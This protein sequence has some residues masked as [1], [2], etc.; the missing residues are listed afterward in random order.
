MDLATGK[1]ITR[2]PRRCCARILT[3]RPFTV[4]ENHRHW[5]DMLRAGAYR[6]W[7]SR[8]YDFYLPR[9]AELLKPHDLGHSERILRER[10]SGVALPGIHTSQLTKSPRNRYVWF[11][12]GIWLFRR[13]LARVPDA[14]LH[15]SAGMTL[16]AQIPLIGSVLPLAFIP[17]VAV[18]HRPRAA[19]RSPASRCSRRFSLTVSVPTAR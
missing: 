2:V 10:L 7:V 8:L 17:G 3:V 9:A 4:E 14:L 12:Q 19:T 11:R 16:V 6:F 15:L 1:S 18:G 13:N 5:G